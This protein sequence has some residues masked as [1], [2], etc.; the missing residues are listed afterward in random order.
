MHY[1]FAWKGASI[2]KPCPLGVATVTF[3]NAEQLNDRPSPRYKNHKH[4]IGLLA[5]FEGLF[6]QALAQWGERQ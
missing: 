2:F 1:D 4:S 3:N 6:D 5:S